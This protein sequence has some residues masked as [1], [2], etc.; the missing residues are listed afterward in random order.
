MSESRLMIVIGQVLAEPWLSISRDGQFTTWIRDPLPTNVVLRHSFGRPPG[1]VLRQ[2]DRWHEWLRWHGR[3]RTIVPSIDALIGRRWLDAS[4][5]VHPEW[6]LDER[7]I[8]WRQDIPDVYALQRWKILGSLDM[9][10]QEDFDYV[11]FTTASSYVRPDRLVDMIR[12]LPSSGVYAGTPMVD[13]FSGVTFASGASR[14]MS[15]DVVRAVL[16]NRRR[17]VNDAMEDAG[18]G[19]LVAELGVSLIEWP[20]V[21]VDSFRTLA[22]L[23]EEDIRDNFHFRMRSGPNRAR[24]DVPLMR[25]LH[26]RVHD[27]EVLEQ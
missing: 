19:R 16:E 26:Q 8:G 6:F 27:L 21:N 22:G 14:L 11:Y 1:P 23:S 5:A 7:S 17:Y 25:A 15:R 3:G 4:P 12:G 18:L 13:A 2:F 24:L 9:A 20:S 10:I